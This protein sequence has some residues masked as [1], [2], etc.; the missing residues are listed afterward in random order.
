MH[1]CQDAVIFHRYLLFINT[2]QT[3]YKSVLQKGL[4]VRKKG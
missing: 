3:S 4:M 2:V 1:Q